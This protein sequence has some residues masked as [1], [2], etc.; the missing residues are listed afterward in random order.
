M[1]AGRRSDHVASTHCSLN[2]CCLIARLPDITC[3]WSSWPAASACSAPNSRRCS[4]APF[5]TSIRLMTA[6]RARHESARTRCMLP[7][8]L[9]FAAAT[10][11][12]LC[13]LARCAQGWQ[14]LFWQ[15]LGS[16]SWTLTVAL[17]ACN[18]GKRES[19][20][21]EASINARATRLVAA[22]QPGDCISGRADL[23][24]KSAFRQYSRV[25]TDC[26]CHMHV[27]NVVL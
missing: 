3:A 14:F 26:C 12:R 10:L 18:L 25:E 11:E 20:T 1:H 15:W 4:R 22:C 8:L 17:T 24:T 27:R 19:V 16:P 23:T 7:T 21:N 5:T 9:L 2:H 6:A 13:Q